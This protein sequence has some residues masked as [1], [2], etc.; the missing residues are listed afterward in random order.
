MNRSNIKIM[1]SVFLIVTSAIAL[2]FGINRVN[3]INEVHLLIE[4]VPSSYTLENET[5]VSF[6]TTESINN[7]SKVGDF[8]SPVLGCNNYIFSRGFTEWHN[9]VDLAQAGGCP[10]DAAND[11][12]VTFA[13]WNEIGGGYAIVIKHNDKYETVYYHGDGTMYVKQGDTVKKGDPIM[14][15]GCTGNCTGTHLHF[16]IIKD[17]VN[18]NPEEYLKF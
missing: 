1:L 8:V 10:I 9:G 14:H 18:L 13:G 3:A 16:E 5:P 4:D 6:A 2:L 7:N 12:T 17:G 15:M 11:G